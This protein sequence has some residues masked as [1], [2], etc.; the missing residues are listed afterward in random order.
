MRGVKRNGHATCAWSA[1]G[2]RTVSGRGACVRALG[3]SCRPARDVTVPL[4]AAPVEARGGASAAASESR[5]RTESLLKRHNARPRLRTGRCGTGA[6]GLEPPTVRLTVGCSAIELHPIMPDSRHGENISAD[7]SAQQR[8]EEFFENLRPW[9]RMLRT[10][11]PTQPARHA[12]SIPRP[13]R[14]ARHPARAGDRCPR[15]S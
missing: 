13:T 15:S 3:L 8:E 10:D 12:P 2:V 14:P 6:G 5:G 9:P 4:V 1:K 11:A 7:R